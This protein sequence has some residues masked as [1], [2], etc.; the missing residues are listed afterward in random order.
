MNKC[1]PRR[2]SCLRQMLNS[3]TPHL[4]IRDLGYE[5]IFEQTRI[6]PHYQGVG[7]IQ[8][9]A[10]GVQRTAIGR[11][12]RSTASFATRGKQR[13]SKRAGL[14]AVEQLRRTGIE[15][16]PRQGLDRKTCISPGVCGV[17]VPSRI[18]GVRS[19]DSSPSETRAS[20][21]IGRTM[22]I[23]KSLTTAGAGTCLR[24]RH[25]RP[26]MIC[27]VTGVKASIRVPP[28]IG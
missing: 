25:P 16:P 13:S 22:P 3:G 23:S 10:H 24:C 8:K 21:N 12:V 14:P 9:A 7:R 20:R 5:R 18:I 27:L 28:T 4:P 26:A 6:G 17:F 15:A 19:R 1:L 11:F 2:L